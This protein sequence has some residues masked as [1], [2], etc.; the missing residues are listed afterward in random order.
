MSVSWEG[1]ETPLTGVP[2]SVLNSMSIAP[3]RKAEI[4]GNLI[5]SYN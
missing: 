2:L 5:L 3:S 1:Q 4:N